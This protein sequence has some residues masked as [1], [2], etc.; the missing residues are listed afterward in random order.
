[1]V[2]QRMM[3]PKI[4]TNTPL[5]CGSGK[6]NAERFGHLFGVGTAADIEEVGQLAAVELDEVHRAH[7]QAGTIHQASNGAVE[8]DVTRARLFVRN[9][10]WLLLPIDHAFPVTLDGGTMRCR[11][12]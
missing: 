2:V 10:R 9:F 11:R 12:N 7:R 4:L 3:P 5:T 8:L 6:R 1:M